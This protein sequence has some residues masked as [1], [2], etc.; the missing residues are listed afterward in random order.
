MHLSQQQAAPPKPPGFGISSVHSAY[1]QEIHWPHV[2]RRLHFG[3]SP[4]AIKYPLA[5]AAQRVQ[6]TQTG[7]TDY[8]P[9]QHH[10]WSPLQTAYA[11][12]MAAAIQTHAPR[13][14]PLIPAH[15]EF[16]M[17]DW[18]IDPEVPPTLCL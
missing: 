4:A 8:G 12:P 10:A 6:H 17:T 13:A 5:N 14:R 18:N 2:E 15:T 3:E 16:D 11:S 9:G 7:F 1:S